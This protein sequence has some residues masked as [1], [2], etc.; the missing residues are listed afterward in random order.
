M[1]RRV[2]SFAASASIALLGAGAPTGLAAGGPAWSATKC[3]SF[4]T[5]WYHA[6][7]PAHAT[8]AQLKAAI[9]EEKLLIKEHRCVFGG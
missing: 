7:V 3:R 4:Y 1:R 5:A 8:T 9:V 6:H 2:L